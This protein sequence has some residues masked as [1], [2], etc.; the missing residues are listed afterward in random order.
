M[1]STILSKKSFLVL[2]GILLAG[3]LATMLVFLPRN[4]GAAMVTGDMHGYAWSDTVGW[5]SLNCAEGG[6]TG[7]SICPTSNYKVSVVSNNFTGY[8]WSDNVGWISFKSADVALCGG[9]SPTL[10]DTTGEISG[11][12]RVL[13]A[14]TTSAANGCMSLRGSGYGLRYDAATP[15][16]HYPAYKKV[17]GFAWGDLVVGWTDFT[18]AAL[19]GGVSTSGLW[20][21]RTTY[22]DQTVLPGTAHQQVAE[23]WV[24]NL[25]TT[26]SVGLTKLTVKF[27]AAGAPMTNFTSFKLSLDDTPVSATF[28]PVTGSPDT[29]TVNVAPKVLGTT[30]TNTTK[31]NVYANFGTSIGGTFSTTLLANGNGVTTGLGV[32]SGSAVMGQTMTIGTIPS[33]AL[34]LLVNGMPSVTLSS[35]AG[36][37]A[38][39]SWS[40]G[41]SIASC[42]A[43][44]DTID[45][46]ETYWY[47]GDPS[48]VTLPTGW[49]GPVTIPANTTSSV[50]HHV[51][52]LN[53]TT[54]TGSSISDTVTVDVPGIVPSVDLK[55]NGVDGPIAIP[56]GGAVALSWTST[57]VTSCTVDSAGWLT[58]DSTYWAVG[59]SR[60]TNQALPPGWVVVTPMAPGTYEYGIKCMR[61][62]T[63]VDDS[64]KITID[65]TLTPTTTTGGGT[66][67]G[68]TTTGASGRP[69][70]RE[71]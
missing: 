7:G 51:Y 64:V 69:P 26:E 38:T 14:P 13:S 44:R 46:G 70:W 50:A 21:G 23:Y 60:T 45:S 8:A 63:L 24:K 29:Y 30:T 17:S 34:H 54:S 20:V 3:I 4:A 2:V 15:S 9:S 61:P 27:N 65:P 48:P 67:G 22:G 58:T 35:P 36:G 31:V 49:K 28:T 53:C 6:A 19:D 25:S 37:P 10:N 39:F 59:A 11:W 71:I 41:S 33:T 66:G 12:V 68:G 62:G 1:T 18:Y 57:D 5:I 42:T 55:V 56:Y 43:V 16:P 32:N 47:S 52:G 40:A